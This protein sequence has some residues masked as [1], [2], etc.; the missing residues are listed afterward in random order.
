MTFNPLAENEERIAK[1]IVDAAYTVHK[2]FAR[3]PRLSEP[4]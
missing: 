2:A 4:K 1:Q 3:P